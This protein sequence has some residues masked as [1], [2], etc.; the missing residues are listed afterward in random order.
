MPPQ[1]CLPPISFTC[2]AATISQ[3]ANAPAPPA[4]NSTNPAVIPCNSAAASS[5]LLTISIASPTSAKPSATTPR[6]PRSSQPSIA[7]NSLLSFGAHTLALRVGIYSLFVPLPQLLMKRLRIPATNPLSAPRHSKSARLNLHTRR[8]A[9]L[10]RKRNVPR[11]RSPSRKPTVPLLQQSLRPFAQRLNHQPSILIKH[12]IRLAILQKRI[13]QSIRQMLQLQHKRPTQRRPLVR[14]YRAILQLHLVR[15]FRS[16]SRQSWQP[17]HRPRNRPRNRVSVLPFRIRQHYNR[18]P[19]FRKIVEAPAVP[20]QRPMLT[21]PPVLLLMIQNHRKPILR[22][23]VRRAHMRRSTFR[24]R[25]R[26]PGFRL[27]Q[28]LLANRPPQR[29]DVPHRAAKPQIRVV[30]HVIFK[31]RHKSLLEMPVRVR[32]PLHQRQI[33]AIRSLLHSR[34][35]ENI[36]PHIRRKTLSAHSLHN[37]HQQ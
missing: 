3:A 13:V 4:I 12:A 26:R 11:R 22:L 37:R 14:R 36:L 24:R 35:L 16:S 27:H 25:H 17:Q 20:Q 18:Q 29:V 34:R 21:D 8:A 28:F 7:A 1:T 33:I 5:S 19:I 31:R 2:C 30:R 32:K 9:I 23:G 10:H 15:R 6:L